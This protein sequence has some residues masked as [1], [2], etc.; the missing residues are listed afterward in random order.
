M[1]N[2]IMKN[3]GQSPFDSFLFQGHILDEKGNKMSKSLGNVLDANDLV[4][5]NSVD[6][7]RFY[8]MWKSSPIESLSFSLSEMGSR[9]Y[10][11]LSTLYYLHV[12]LI[13]NSTYDNFD[14]G[15]INI[16]SIVKSRYFGLTEI[17]ILSKLQSLIKTV[18][19]SLDT[20]RF[21][22]GAKILEEFIINNV[23]QTYVPMTRDDIWDDN[24]ETKERR[25]VIYAVLG[26]TLTQ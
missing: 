26:H 2:V 25:H 16:D 13:Q 8:L 20:C 22:E 19:S 12:Y 17:W 6:A 9:P 10:Q 15:E 7:I 1:E 11:I 4:V 3:K 14:T 5:K 21:N 18:T 24:I 23:S